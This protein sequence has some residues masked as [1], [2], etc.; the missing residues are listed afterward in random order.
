MMMMSS[1]IPL[2]LI[3]YNFFISSLQT[4]GKLAQNHA[5]VKIIFNQRHG[6][7]RRRGDAP[8]KAGKVG[9]DLR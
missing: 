9:A 6:P 7:E 2:F 8:A 3:R 5:V 4:K 1:F